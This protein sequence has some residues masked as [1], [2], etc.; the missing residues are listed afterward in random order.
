MFWICHAAVQGLIISSL[1]SKV[2]VLHSLKIKMTLINAS[3]HGTIFFLLGG[4][5][6]KLEN[7]D[8][9]FR[10]GSGNDDG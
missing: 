7:D 1:N 6:Q 8:V 3:K 9:I 5:G 4:G 10:G 2:K